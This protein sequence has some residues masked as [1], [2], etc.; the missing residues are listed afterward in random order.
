[1]IV[2]TGTKVIYLGNGAA[3]EYPITFGYA[4]PTTVK[5]GI[6]DPATEQTVELTKDYYVDTVRN[7]VF[8]PGYAPGQAPPE[9]EQPGALPAGKKLVI[10]RA[11]PMDQT[12]DL[13][14]KYPLPIIEKI[15]DKNTLIEQELAEKL[16][17][18]VLADIGSGKTVEDIQREIREDRL[19]AEK[20]AN[21]AQEAKTAADLAQ[22]WA[23]APYPPN[24]VD[25][26]KSAK[27]WAKEA[28]ENGAVEAEKAKHW[29][30]A[31]KTS[32]EIAQTSA[33]EVS[34]ILTD[35][36]HT[37]LYDPNRAYTPGKC[38]MVENGDVY[39]CTRESR[40]ENPVTSPK[41]VSVATTIFRT[42]ELDEHGDLMPLKYPQSSTLWSV[43]DNGDI[44][45][46]NI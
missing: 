42:F 28:Q 14:T 4:D 20:A 29:A 38:A 25:G 41:W 36:N 13:G 18:A 23:E 34:R 5:V 43:D 6:Y 12:I 45:A 30:E 1:M 17:R 7:A 22:A 8:Y 39:R 24:G 10:Y 46:A 32:E 37:A 27:M 16:G 44:M 2:T 26:S 3:R 19:A 31:A 11:T 40:G 33:A 15:G 9:S 21:E 35:V